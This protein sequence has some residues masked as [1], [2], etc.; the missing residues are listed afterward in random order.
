[1]NIFKRRIA[2]K[3]RDNQRRLKWLLYIWREDHVRKETMKCQ[4]RIKDIIGVGLV[5]KN[6]LNKNKNVPNDTTMT[7]PLS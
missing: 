4:M 2:Q 1:M 3:Y 5:V 6:V 7:V